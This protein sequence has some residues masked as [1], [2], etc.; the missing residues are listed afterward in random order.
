MA[1]EKGDEDV[2]NRADRVIEVT[3]KDEAKAPSLSLV[4]KQWVEHFKK[5]VDESICKN[6]LDV[7]DLVALM[8]IA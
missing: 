3:K 8:F 2:N 1:K 7:E 4:D 6:R 5:D